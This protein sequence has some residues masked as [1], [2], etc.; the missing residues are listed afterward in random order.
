ML[1]LFVSNV[2]PDTQP[3][4]DRLEELGLQFKVIDITENMKNLKHFLSYRDRLVYFEDIKKN[5]Q[6]GVPLLMVGEG[7][8]FILL[9]DIDK[10][11]DKELEKLKRYE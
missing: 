4:L 3:A 2:C 6:V 9:E 1:T 8:E 7:E 11:K 10:I 5:N